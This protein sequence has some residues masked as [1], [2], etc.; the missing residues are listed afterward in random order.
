MVKGRGQEAHSEF[1][2]QLKERLGDA[3]FMI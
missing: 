2:R 3:A 1:Y